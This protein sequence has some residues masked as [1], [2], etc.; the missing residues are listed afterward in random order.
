MQDG[1]LKKEKAKVPFPATDITDEKIT[2]EELAKLMDDYK[3]FT[4]KLDK[5]VSNE[6]SSTT[7]TINEDTNNKKDDTLRGCFFLRPADINILTNITNFRGI[8]VYLGYK[9]EKEVVILLPVTKRSTEED[10]VTQDSTL[11]GE[12]KTTSTVVILNSDKKPCPPIPPNMSSC[13]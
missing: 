12:T 8:S 6:D 9:D 11:N 2:K 7:S 13:P 10:V 5:N 3:A 4:K 1:N